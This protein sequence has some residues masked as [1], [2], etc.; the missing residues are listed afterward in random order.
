MQQVKGKVKSIKTF[1]RFQGLNWIKMTF[2]TI[3]IKVIEY[4][5]MQQV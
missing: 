3:P 1:Q 5:T 4:N 2:K